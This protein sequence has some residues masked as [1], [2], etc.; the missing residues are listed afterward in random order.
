MSSANAA[1]ITGDLGITGN[2]GASGGNNLG[3]A[4]TITLSSATGTSGTDVIGSTVTFG[5]P[6]TINNGAISINPSA[7]QANV[8]V[9]GGW[10]F[11]LS[12]LAI[13]DQTTILLTMEGTGVLSGNGFD[14]TAA[15]WTFSSQ[16]ASSYSMT[17]SAV[18]VPAAVWLFGS[19]LVGLIAVA[20]RKVA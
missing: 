3:D 18:P 1:F 15:T 20:R 16:G 7:A 5:T 2:Y 12:T 13:T 8:F 10:Q 19:G 6:G 14:S 4:T 9:I 11:D 17:I